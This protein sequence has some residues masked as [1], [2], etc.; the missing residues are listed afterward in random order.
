MWGYQTIFSSLNSPYNDA[1]LLISPAILP[2][3]A[4]AARHGGADLIN[5]AAARVLSHVATTSCHHEEHAE[6][7][8]IADA[9][10]GSFCIFRKYLG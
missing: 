8:S 4:P 2:K 10:S 6:S 7:C 5:L 3:A 9:Q 1:F